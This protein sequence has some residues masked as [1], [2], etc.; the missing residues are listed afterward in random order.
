MSFSGVSS[1]LAIVL[2]ISSNWSRNLITQDQFEE[3]VNTI[4]NLLETPEKDM[5]YTL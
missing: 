5:W 3:I 4:A 2:T 1:K